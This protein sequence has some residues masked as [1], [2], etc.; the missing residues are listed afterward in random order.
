[1]HVYVVLKLKATAGSPAEQLGGQENT[2]C[3][4][5]PENYWNKCI[6]RIWMP[7]HS[8]EPTRDQSLT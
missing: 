5:K 6:V 4:K 2:G 1:M 8:A 7:Q 3:P